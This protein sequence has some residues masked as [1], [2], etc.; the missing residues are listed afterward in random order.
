M[1]TP[2]QDPRTVVR[3][4]E[5]SWSDEVGRAAALEGPV[6]IYDPAYQFNNGREF[7]EKDHYQQN[8]S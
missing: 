8:E 2:N 1:S 4:S 5:R 7:L 3:I 6:P